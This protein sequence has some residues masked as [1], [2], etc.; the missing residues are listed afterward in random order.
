MVIYKQIIEDLKGIAYHNPQI[1]SFGFGDITQLT[2]DIENKVSPVYQKMY[3]V[4]GNVVLKE[5]AIQYNLSVIVMDLINSDY[6]N[7][8]EVMSDTI[9]T[10][11]DIWT[12]LYQSYTQY[13]GGFTLDYEPLWSPTIEPFL[14]SY[15]DILGGWTMSLVIE[16][17]FDYN[18]CVIPDSDIFP[19]DESFSSYYQIIQDFKNFAIQHRQVNSFGYGDITQLTMDVSTKVEPVYPKLYFVPQT[20][21]FDQNHMHITWDVLIVD[22]LNDD[23]SN[24]LEVLSDTLEIAKDFFART[25]LS[26]Y[27]ADWD[28]DIQ[29]WLEETETILCGWTMRLSITQKFDFNRCVLP[30]LPFENKKWYELATKWNE[31]N[32]DWKNT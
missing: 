29:P 16:E 15:E 13:Y 1:N 7:Q 5:N 30:E 25:Y 22:Q 11:K 18:S 31:V 28:A 27:E 6:S 17:G 10:I 32:T 23:Y 9:E 20:T 2:M 12:I 14:E 24:Q 21:R 3:V 4:P 8:Q 26:D 19:Q